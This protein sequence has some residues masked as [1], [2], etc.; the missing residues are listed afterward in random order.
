MA[1]MTVHEA[2]CE[3]KVADKRIEKA[4]KEIDR[5]VAEKEKEIMEV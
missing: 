5:I 2:L 1:K 3:I 4:I